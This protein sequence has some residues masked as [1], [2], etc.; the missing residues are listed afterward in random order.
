MLTLQ[1]APDS[2]FGRLRLQ[3]VLPR[4][5]TQAERAGLF[6]DKQ[7]SHEREQLAAVWLMQEFSPLDRRISLEGVGLLNFR[8]VEPRDWTPL[9]SLLASPWNV[10]EADVLALIH[11]LMNTLRRQGAHTYLLSERVDLLKDESFAPRQKAFYMREK[12]GRAKLGYGILGWMPQDGYSNGRF[13][14]LRQWLVR[15]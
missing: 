14:L 11:L 15:Q 13:E 8:P 5:I 3:D 7:G 1:D 6:T 10:T 4:L 12:G 9:P 2:S